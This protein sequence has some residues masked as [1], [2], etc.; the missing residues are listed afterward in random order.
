[1]DS[2]LIF[3]LQMTGSET[4]VDAGVR[5]LTATQN[6]C[7]ELSNKG[8][9]HHAGRLGFQV[10]VYAPGYIQICAAKRRVSI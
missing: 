9:F 6:K 5:N 8:I 2:A 7:S 4:D 10:Y 3:L 1:M